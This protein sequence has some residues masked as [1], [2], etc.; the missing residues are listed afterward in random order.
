M[1]TRTCKKWISP[2][3][4][5]DKLESFLNEGIHQQRKS[6]MPSEEN[7]DFPSEGSRELYHLNRFEFH[8]G[9]HQ[10]ILL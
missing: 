8:E 7:S 5:K 2:W 6:M 10:Y 4:L 9:A 1:S 3:L